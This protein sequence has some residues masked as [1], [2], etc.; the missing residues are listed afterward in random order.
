LIVATSSTG[1]TRP[2]TCI[3]YDKIIIFL[4]FLRYLTK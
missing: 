3:T 2:S 1:F 4:L